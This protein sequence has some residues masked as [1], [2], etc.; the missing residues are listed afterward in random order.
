M[1]KKDEDEGG[2]TKR[3]LGVREYKRE[4][5]SRG[6]KEREEKTKLRG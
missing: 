6:G 5:H 2:W 4:Y 3:E 1:K